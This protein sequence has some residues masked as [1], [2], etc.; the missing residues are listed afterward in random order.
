[1]YLLSLGALQKIF[2]KLFP[3]ITHRHSTS[4]RYT[5]RLV[6]VVD[7]RPHLPVLVS[8]AFRA[9]ASFVAGSVRAQDGGT[10]IVGFGP[11]LATN[12]ISGRGKPTLSIGQAA[13]L[14]C[15]VGAE[16]GECTYYATRC[17]NW[18]GCQ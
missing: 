5:L 17:G 11:V 10:K 2:S 16:T 12:E 18:L 3:Q 7:T 9:V 13:T 8:S 14:A 15:V 1:M 6:S 4:H